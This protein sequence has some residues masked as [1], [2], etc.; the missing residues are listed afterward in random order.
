M[1]NVLPHQLWIGTIDDEWPLQAFGRKEE[2]KRWLEQSS[3]N[4]TK[5][6]WRLEV[7]KAV[8][9][10]LTARVEQELIEVPGEDDD[11]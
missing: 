5:R 11:G 8:E 4:K 10:T 9:M 6:L 7:V 1:A 2:A 3:R